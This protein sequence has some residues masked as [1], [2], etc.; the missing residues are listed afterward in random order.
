MIATAVVAAVLVLSGQT[1]GAVEE[2]H[3]VI[4]VTG[5][6]HER[7]IECRGRAVEVAG[8]NHDLTF[9]GT[10]SRLELTGTG[11]TVTINLA[12]DA[13]LVVAGTGQVVRYRAEGRVRQNVTGVGNRVSRLDR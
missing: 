11:N 9:T 4:S 5:M 3:E 8:T 1:V 12:A 7:T 6:G 13:P 2:G 10:C